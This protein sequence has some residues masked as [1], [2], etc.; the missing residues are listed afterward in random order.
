MD[1]VF[2]TKKVPNFLH[3]TL[4][5]LIPK[6]QDSETLGNYRPISLCNTVYKIITKLIVTRI[7]SHLDNIIS[8]Y[9]I[10]FILRRRGTDNIIIA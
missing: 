2:T 4:I 3:K 5:V 1:R 10:A 6:I 8:P 9:Q 7:R